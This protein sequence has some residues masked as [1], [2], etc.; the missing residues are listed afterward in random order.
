M[1]AII[2]T[3]TDDI[4][5]R[6]EQDLGM[7]VSRRDTWAKTG[8]AKT[9]VAVSSS[10]LAQRLATPMRRLGALVVRKAKHLGIEFRPGAR[11]RTTPSSSRWVANS[12]RRA[13]TVRLGRR[14]GKRVFATGL[15]PAVMYGATV[16]SL[17][18]GN[19]VAMRRAAG[20]AI[21]KMQGRSLTARLAVNQCDPGWD[22]VRGPVMA[23]TAEAWC[24]RIPV[25]TMQ[26]A[27]MQAQ[28]GVNRSSR[29]HM[30]SGGAAGA[31]FTALN[32]V[33]WK[34]P[35]YNLV[36]TLDGSTLDLTEQ[37]PRTIERYLKDDYSIA[38]SSITSI[39]KAMNL[40]GPNGPVGGH[41]VG[42]QSA[43]DPKYA[44]HKGKAVPWFEPAA[45]V[46]NSTQC[47]AMAPSAVA[48]VA[49]IPEGG[50][51]TQSKLFQVG[52]AEDPFCRLCGAAE[53]T[54]HHRMFN[55]PTRKEAMESECPD[56]LQQNADKNRDDPLYNLGV[57]KR[58][59]C[60]RP[61]P[62]KEAWVGGPPCGG[63][64][65]AGEAYTD[66][67]LRGTVPKARRGGWAYVVRNGDEPI[68]G[69]FGICSDAYLT[70]LRT[71]LHALVEI[72]RVTVGPIKIFVDNQQ[73]VDGVANG[74]AW[75]CSPNRDGADLWP[76]IWRR[77]EDLPGLVTVLKVKA[78]LQYSDVV[79][80]RIPWG[81]W[82]GN[83][84]ADLWAKRGSAEAERLSPCS[85]IHSEW[86][87]AR[88]YYKWALLIASEWLVDTE[89]AAED[90]A[91]PVPAPPVARPRTAPRDYTVTHELWKNRSHG[92]CRLCG[93]EAP[94][95]RVR[96]PPAFR[97]PCRG[98]M[99]V[100]CGIIG[101]EHAVS[102]RPHAYD[103]GC[104]SL[105]TLRARGAEKI[106]HAVQPYDRSGGRSTP[107]LGPPAS[108]GGHAREDAM[109]AS[110]D[111]E[112]EDPFGHTHLPM[113][114][115]DR[116][117]TANLDE[118]GPFLKSTTA[119]E[120]H[121]SHALTRHANLVWCR[122][123]GRHAFARLGVG[124]LGPCRGE[125][126]GGY[127]SRL[128]RMRS[129]CHPVTGKPLS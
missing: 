84:L 48:S 37:A 46:V 50:W 17:G 41:A 32:T 128:A 31:F 127:P 125:A 92:W 64:A 14:L 9:V 29:H 109:P 56:K 87:R 5:G 116:G 57:P 86:S 8:K 53:G 73:V 100:R 78:H 97:R 30:S 65:A 23:W 115:D 24:C 20:K 95:I 74:R 90:T 52:I 76:E 6:L 68:W 112:D 72:L 118:G 62:A 25:R 10:K 61:H 4:I 108:L 66:G 43:I 12:A 35:S 121:K 105:A 104:V 19:I 122:S 89:L 36:I 26:R 69:K 111:Y 47:K 114:Y 99:G 39:S 119:H 70:V 113:G 27:W 16:A 129:G 80:G 79:S 102:P 88:A 11:T 98:S 124:L 44:E 103:E 123:C 1:A 15:K 82:I 67:A 40:S 54:L 33:G 120:A 93:I 55:C 83:G 38:S 18:R 96:P 107:E 7:K 51:W 77:L 13:R 101:R 59:H 75:C 58:P 94:W 42:Q 22:A 106:L 110:A 81:V 85:W 126:T 2:S 60:P 91:Q 63:A 34:S 117:T 49:S 3:C 71:E 28:L 21:G 45:S